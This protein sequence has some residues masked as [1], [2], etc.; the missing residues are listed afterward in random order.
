[1]TTTLHARG[2]FDVTVSPLDPEDTAE[3]STVGRF[4]LDKR[5]H[6]PLDAAAKGQ[7]LTAGSAAV[8]GSA[9]YAAVERVTGTIDGRRG[10]FALVHR[11]VMGG[12]TEE[13]LIT[14]V[15]DSGSGA[16]T[17]LAGTLSI[18][19]VDGQHHYDFAYT[20]PAA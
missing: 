19:I 16:L 3:G 18:T 5:Y 10:S 12:G 9:A 6:G 11:G 2:T 13:L 8:R 14:V 1:M 7:M 4:A 15:P 17:G 20:L